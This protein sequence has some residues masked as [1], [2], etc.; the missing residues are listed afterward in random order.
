MAGLLERA[1]HA[2]AALVL[3]GEAG[4]G[5]TTA[6]LRAIEDAAAQGV[7]VLVAR[8]APT[9]VTFAYAAIADL[10]R[11]VEEST[12][13]R[14]PAR[15]STAVH[16]LL[17]GE[18]PGPGT[19]ERA[20]GGAFV[21]VLQRMAADGPMLVAIDDAHWLDTAS[22]AVLSFAA[23]RLSGQIALL[24]AAR[25]GDGAAPGTLS[26]LRLGDPEAIVRLRVRPLSLGATHALISHR[27]G[28]TLPRPTMVRI[29][30]TSGGNPFF[31]LE[32]ARAVT[33]SDTQT[34]AGLPESLAAVVR[35]R[36]AQL[37]E[38]SRTVML[39]V[40]CVAQPTVELIA[41]VTGESLDDVVDALDAAVRD[42]LLVHAGNRVEFT[43]PLLAHGVY[44]EATPAQRRRMH[45]RLAGEVKQ[46]ELRARHLALAAVGPDAETLAALDAAAAAAAARG[47]P[48]VAAEL[49]DLAIGL[50]GD[51]ALRRLRAADRYFRAG[52]LEAAQHHLDAVLDGPGAG[53]LQPVAL[54]LQGALHSFGGSVPA[55]VQALERAVEE[56]GENV[57]V[58]AQA[59]MILALLVAATGRRAE[60]VEHAAAAVQTAERLGGPALHSQALAIWLILRFLHGR[61][62]DR[63]ALQTALHCQDA[64]NAG[65]VGTRAD[66]IAA[67]LAAWQGRL[68]EGRAGI[69]AVMHL[70]AERGAETDVIWTACRST[71]IDI[72][73][74][75]Y[76]DAAATAAQALEHAEQIGGA[77]TL[78]EALTAT[79]AAAA[80]TGDLDGARTAA[81]RA[82]QSARDIGA[83]FL[84]GAPLTTLAFLDVSCGEY[85]AAAVTLEPLLAA[86]D[87]EHDTEMVV[88]GFLPDAI[89]AL[90]ALGRCAEAEPLV[91]ALEG[92]GVRLGRA[93]MLA[94]GARGRAQIL[95]AAGDLEAAERAALAACEHHRELPMPFETAR[96]QLLL[97]QLQRR[98][99]QRRAAAETLT[100]ALGTFEELGSPLWSARVR[101]ELDRLNAASAAGV[102][103]LTPA[104]TRVARLAAAGLSNKEIAAELSLALKTVEMNLSAVY[105]K[106]DIRSRAQLHCRLD[107]GAGAP[108]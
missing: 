86:F 1:R 7:R 62:A 60:A 5:K 11:T 14:L 93:W 44:T 108:P 74:G 84:A 72:W 19:D 45:R 42:G 73:L 52:A 58:R 94:V 17:L 66:A 26:W 50:G 99:R 96:T 104:E 35:D 105:R 59:L 25:S 90:V 47:A 87:P 9:E 70:C 83:D 16:R 106:L 76:P 55:G 28:Y 48:S 102:S 56:S 77:Q 13:A 34:P 8:G 75:R 79:A 61:D 80:Y 98:R 82:V 29:H 38:Q 22:R 33:D 46:S 40:S 64:R 63:T 37:S 91:A 12:L 2:P 6:W 100:V 49:M 23:P 20:V 88:G 41:A 81:R 95:A 69:A 71:M 31:A 10:V 39:A 30:E 36:I 97:G 4:I 78:V 3:E 27:L 103:G 32:L 101:D 43:H 65:F 21:A 51:S 89:E 24:V 67:V 85:G 68:E 57:D 53:R 107:P 92:N 18:G 54:I 15:L